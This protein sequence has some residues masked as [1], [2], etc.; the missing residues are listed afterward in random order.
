MTEAKNANI[1]SR[2]ADVFLILEQ[3]IDAVLTK[4]DTVA[5]FTAKGN[6]FDK[7]IRSK[8]GQS[9]V[10]DATSFRA[11]KSSNAKPPKI[12][13]DVL[14]SYEPFINDSKYALS[15]LDYLV[16][17][18]TSVKNIMNDIAPHI[19]DL[20]IRWNYPLVLHISKLL[21]AFSKICTLVHSHKILY[22]LIQ[23][24]PIIPALKEL[25]LN[26]DYEK[27]AK[28]ISSATKSP[29]SYAAAQFSK[30]EQKISDFISQ[31]S[32]NIIQIFG[33]WPVVEWNDFSVF[34]QIEQTYDSTL[35]TNIHLVLENIGLFRDV[36][37][38]FGLMF[39]QYPEMFPQ[40]LTLLNIALTEG[41]M[42]NLT[43]TVSISVAEILK[44]FN[45]TVKNKSISEMTEMNEYER[46]LKA[47]ISHPQRLNHVYYL[48]RDISDIT[49][50]EPS[51]LP[52]FINH[53][54]PLASLACYEVNQYFVEEAIK[55]SIVNLV[56]ILT[57]LGRSFKI[58]ENV[59]KRFFLFN[60][61]TIDATF[62][63]SLHSSISQLTEL[64]QVHIAGL[65]SDL[66]RALGSIDLEDFDRGTRYDLMPFIVTANRLFFLF[67]EL[68]TKFQGAFL[69][70]IFE[71]LA[72]IIFHANLAQDPFSYF[73]TFVPLHKFWRYTDMIM[74]YSE[75]L[76]GGIGSC[77]SL[78]NLFQFF[79][80]DQIGISLNEKV[81]NTVEPAI[82]HIRKEFLKK[83]TS[84]IK[85]YLSKDN[86]FIGISNHTSKNII[87]DPKIYLFN[88]TNFNAAQVNAMDNLRAADLQL[89]QFALNIPKKVTF[90]GH[91]FPITSYICDHIGKQLA[92]LM[93]DK[94][95]P[96]VT[97][98][99]SCF[100][101]TPELLWPLYCQM[102][103]SYPKQLVE[104]RYSQGNIPGPLSYLDKIS[105]IKNSTSSQTIKEEKDEAIIITLQRSIQK[106]I[107]KGIQNTIYKTYGRRFEKID[108][109]ISPAMEQLLSYDGFLGLFRNLGPQ[110][111]FWLNKIIV[112]EIGVIMV[113][114]FKIHTSIIDQISNWFNMYRLK[115]YDW[116]PT[117]IKSDEVKHCAQE[118]VRLGSILRLRRLIRQA[119]SDMMDTMVEGFIPILSSAYIRERD[120]QWG[121]K[122]DFLVEMCTPFQT[123][124]FIKFAIE[125]ANLLKTTNS[126]QFFFFLALLL[127][128][129]EWS[130]ID[131]NYDS[132]TFSGNLHNI[133]D[134]FDAFLSINNCFVADADDKKVDDAL[135]VFFD[136]FSHVIQWKRKF[137]G[138]TGEFLEDTMIILAD[139]FPKFVSK[140]QYGTIAE[141]FPINVVL[142]AY[143]RIDKEKSVRK[144]Q[145]K[146]KRGRRGK[147]K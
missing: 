59:I 70:P 102:G 136:T 145:G 65:I 12:S 137:S 66:I 144:D 64:W 138:E 100:S 92:E 51:Y 84:V 56:E 111:A 55:D 122:Q 46:Q 77:S 94:K 52:K 71:H 57:D 125:K 127:L 60:L 9:L 10:K 113:N 129:P 4:F 34:S 112:N 36:I 24:Y 63:N 126:S 62:L 43:P 141:S 146:K 72:T 115:K 110:A 6:D 140:L 117:A 18:A 17:W 3:H 44:T 27:I 98:M 39:P 78:I 7:F 99:T 21:V 74:K 134:A 26:M 40:Y 81:V 139:I 82:K 50:F 120:A 30:I 142:D 89:K 5:V 105:M 128:N 15:A 114:I 86:F 116:V 1:T 11:S 107:T 93:F 47:D 54:L 130:N 38:F 91:E 68:Q 101:A 14:K 22:L 132:E 118:F 41:S 28:F 90:K 16:D 49:A 121:E 135:D 48:L 85:E 31:I 124:H 20:D 104:C 42:I 61:T 131:F 143:M 76:P 133:P 45:E 108:E 80:Y 19:T 83:F 69:N 73:L 32:P 58:N 2:R 79:D 109:S 103:I 75:E 35:P 8:H 33:Q 13:S 25:P 88:D 119:A 37:I 23:F 147:K 67:N 123:F 106:F 53:I 95:L 96:D 29:F 87:F 97:W